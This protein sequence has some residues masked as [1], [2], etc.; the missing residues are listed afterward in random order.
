MSHSIT[1]NYAER[2]IFVTNSYAP[3]GVVWSGTNGLAVVS[4]NSTNLVFTPTNSTPSNYVIQV[5]A[6][7]LSN[8]FDTCEVV[9]LK[10]ELTNMTFG[11]GW[12]LVPDTGGTYPTPH[13]TSNN[14]SPYLYQRSS[15]INATATFK[16]EPATYTG[17]ITLSGDGSG[18]LD[19][20]NTTV[21]VSGG[22]AI[23]PATDSTG[24]L[25]NYVDFWNPMQLNWKYGVGGTAA[26]DAGQASNK[27]YVSLAN[28]TTVPTLYHTV[29]HLACSVGHATNEQQAVSNSWS[30]LAG[31]NFTTW[32]GKTLYYYRDGAGWNSPGQVSQL[33]T[34]S[35]ANCVAWRNLLRYALAVNGVG[36]DRIYIAATGP[37]NEVFLVGD[38]TFG[39]AS[40][41]N[42]SPY[43]WRLQFITNNVDMGPRPTGDVYGDLASLTTISGQNTTPPSEKV[44]GNH[45]MVR[46][47]GVYYDPS[48]GV[49]HATISNL[50]ES[51]V[52]GYGYYQVGDPTSNFVLRVKTSTGV[53]EIDEVVNHPSDFSD[54]LP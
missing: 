45:R 29:V 49:T 38:W 34:T 6:V 44:F 14:R 11:K 43:N 28:P 21:A 53:Y 51:A 30:Q 17:I 48:Y 13:W 47:G 7:G 32:E 1:H 5:S 52:D 12:N 10:A 19:F 50:V 3:N 22:F 4:A 16:I 46:Y 8:C 15:H 2:A 9:V 40:F 23:Y 36:S 33:L 42:T 26:A 39:A 18:D 41:S 31:H 24:T 20:T 35:N 37:T 25:T 54:G 27:V